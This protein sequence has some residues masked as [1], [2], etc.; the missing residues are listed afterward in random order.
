MQG[1]VRSYSTGTRLGAQTNSPDIEMSID[2][3][4]FEPWT[5]FSTASVKQCCLAFAEVIKGLPQDQ[6]ANVSFGF[7]GTCSLN[8]TRAVTERDNVFLLSSGEEM[9][10]K[11]TFIVNMYELCWA[12]VLYE[13]KVKS[14][15]FQSRVSVRKWV[16]AAFSATV[17]CFCDFFGDFNN[18]HCHREEVYDRVINILIGLP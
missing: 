2:G 17:D 7:D 10:V 5:T 14:Y 3:V 1:N 8:S 13:T 12:L 6:V 18:L 9:I 4:T 16:S 15:C 11:D